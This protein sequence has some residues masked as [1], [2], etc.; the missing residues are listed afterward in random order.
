LVRYSWHC[1]DDVQTY[2]RVTPKNSTI[3]CTSGLLPK[4]ATEMILWYWPSYG[5]VAAI[6]VVSYWLRALVTN[7]IFSRSQVRD[8]VDIFSVL[9]LH[10]S[11]WVTYSPQDSVQR[12]LLLFLS[13]T[14][15][16]SVASK[17]SL[18]RPMNIN[19]YLHCH[20]SS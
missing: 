1:T 11:T 12:L 14:R 3:S 5:S 9:D 15:E 17:I 20:E 6:G 8:S 10:V 13:T 19:S 7:W 4:H 18:I 16:W 2:I